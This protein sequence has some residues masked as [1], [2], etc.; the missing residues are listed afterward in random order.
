MSNPPMA[1]P[2]TPLERVEGLSGQDAPISETD[3]D[4]QNSQ[5]Y[6]HAQQEVAGVISSSIYLA[7]LEIRMKRYGSTSCENRIAQ[8]VS[9]EV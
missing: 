6:H 9:S 4:E 5:T 8:D 7:T 3:P 2:S 1:G